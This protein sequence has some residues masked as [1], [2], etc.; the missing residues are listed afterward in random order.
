MLGG[1]VNLKGPLRSLTSPAYLGTMALCGLGLWAAD[2]YA[3]GKWRGLRLVAMG[4]LGAGVG[5]GILAP[6]FPPLAAGAIG[7]AQAAANYAPPAS[8]ASSAAATNKSFEPA[9]GVE[10]QGVF[11]GQ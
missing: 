6:L 7:N 4:A 5:Y 8:S 9:Q 3:T 1:W 2:R 11:V 10:S